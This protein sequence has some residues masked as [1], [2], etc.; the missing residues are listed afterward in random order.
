[1]VAC[2]V[3]KSEN[4]PT[5]TIRFT[6]FEERKNVMPHCFHAVLAA[7]ALCRRSPAPLLVQPVQQQIAVIVTARRS[8]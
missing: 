1:R 6:P 7:R 2:Q 3:R 5:R 4:L 8:S